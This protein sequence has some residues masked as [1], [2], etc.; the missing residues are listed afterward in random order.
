GAGLVAAVGPTTADALRAEGLAPEV[1][2]ARPGGL[3][4]VDALV[5]HLRAHPERR[6]ALRARQDEALARIAA[7]AA[8]DAAS[9]D[10]NRGER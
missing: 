3:A 9:G 6:D 8:A 5:D 10:A 4:L 1:V 2:P 7:V